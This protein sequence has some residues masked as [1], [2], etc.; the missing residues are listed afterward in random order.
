MCINSRCGGFLLVEAGVSISLAMVL[1]SVLGLI[2][3][4]DRRMDASDADWVQL[5]AARNA[6]MQWRSGSTPQ[7]PTDVVIEVEPVPSQP[8]LEGIVVHLSHGRCLR[9]VRQR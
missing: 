3:V 7:W 6:L 4:I 5:D 2:V 8:A 9:G 1:M